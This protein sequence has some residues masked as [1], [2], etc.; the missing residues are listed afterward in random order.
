[1]DSSLTNNTSSME[2]HTNIPQSSITT[3]QPPPLPPPP[4]NDHLYWA[5]SL[6]PFTTGSTV[7]CRAQSKSSNW[8]LFA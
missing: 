7:Y 5:A 8:L 1:M 4:M 6:C 3:N 2:G